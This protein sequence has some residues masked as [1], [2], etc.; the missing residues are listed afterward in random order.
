MDDRLLLLHVFTFSHVK[1]S[2]SKSSVRCSVMPFGDIFTSS[3]VMI[4]ISSVVNSGVDVAIC[5]VSVVGS[6]GTD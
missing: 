1:V 5:S 3:L 2:V 4:S 6:C